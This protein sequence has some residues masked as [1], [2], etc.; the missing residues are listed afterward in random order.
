MSIKLE[1]IYYK[2]PVFFQ[3]GAVSALGLKLKRERFTVAGDKMLETLMQSR[4]FS[5]DQIAQYQD[6]EFANIAKHAIHTTQFYS[7][8]ARENGIDPNAISGLKD[9]VL[10]PVIEKNFLRENSAL[11]R[12]TDPGLTRKQFCLHTSGTTGTPLTVWTDKD[13]RS[14]H[15]A[16][17]SRLRAE[18]G[19]A[20]N[21][22]RATLFGRIIMP[23]SQTN[24]PFWRY[25]FFQKNL[26]MSSYHLN[27]KNLGYY[28]HKLAAYKPAEIFAYPSSIYAIAEYIVKHSLA[29][30][31]LKLIMTTAENL[32]PH[33]KAIIKKAFHA[34]VVNQYGCTEMAFFCSEFSDGLMKFHPEHG[35]TEVRHSSGTISTEGSGELIATG[36]INWSM[37]VIRY[38]VGDQ[39]LLTGRDSQGKQIL[40]DVAGRTDDV[41]YTLDGTPIGRL[42]PIFKGGNGIK[43]AQIVQSE[44]GSVN[45]RLVPDEFYTDQHGDA[46]KHELIKRLGNELDISITLLETIEKEK[47]G[48]FKPVISRFK[49]SPQ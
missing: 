20:S 28:Y 15:Y 35:I 21:D 8:W 9:L 10:F 7:N 1:D 42:D 40:G 13:S 46:L 25:D 47:N 18:Y 14:R 37:P 5:S 17:F 44:S 27:E 30:L 32:L 41:I 29:P 6:A 49:R 2:L 48:K 45:L 33:Q 3:N 39:V 34:P 23:A 11:F 24:P 22:K 26:L 31:S 16:F 4:T 12:S 19:V 36:F 43:C 38:A